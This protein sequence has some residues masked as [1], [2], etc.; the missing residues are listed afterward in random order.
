[1]KADFSGIAS[2]LFISAIR[3]KT[4]VEIKEEGT[5][6]TA[7]TGLSAMPSAMGMPPP[8]IPFKMIVD[9]PFLF[10]IED[11]QTGTILFMGLIFD[12]KTD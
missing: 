5:E 3:Q 11:S 9:R 8:P 2:R 4:F 7:V 6:A 10:L 12:P 1:M